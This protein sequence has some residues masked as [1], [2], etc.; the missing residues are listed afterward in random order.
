[1]EI[2]ERLGKKIIQQLLQ[3]KTLPCSLWKVGVSVS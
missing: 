2:A 1:M 3:E